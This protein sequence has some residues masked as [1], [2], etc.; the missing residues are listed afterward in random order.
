MKCSTTCTIQRHKICSK[1]NWNYFKHEGPQQ[2][3]TSVMSQ[4][5]EVT[6][7]NTA[8][9]VQDSYHSYF[10]ENGVYPSFSELG[11]I[12]GIKKQ[13]AHQIIRKGE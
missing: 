6:G 4:E 3:D 8:V 12:C 5:K 10:V 2:N 11:N 9:Y 13:R 1:N 7:I